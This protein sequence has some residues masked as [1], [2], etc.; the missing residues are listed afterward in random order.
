LVSLFSHL[1][2][3]QILPKNIKRE[4]RPIVGKP[5]VIR[6]KR[7]FWLVR[8]GG[9]A[10]ASE[11]PKMIQLRSMFIIQYATVCII[12]VARNLFSPAQN[13]ICKIHDHF[14]RINKI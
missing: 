10:A 6:F 9:G 11:L 4:N 8:V 14:K 7:N 1:H 12:F 13:W 2:L 3:Q 5:I